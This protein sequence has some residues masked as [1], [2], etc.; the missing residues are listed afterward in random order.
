[1]TCSYLYAALFLTLNGKTISNNSYLSFRTLDRNFND[2]L[3]C[4]GRGQEVDWY[5]LNEEIVPQFS[6]EDSSIQSIPTVLY[7]RKYRTTSHLFREGVSPLLGQYFCSTTD[8]IVY[9]HIGKT[10]CS[11]SAPCM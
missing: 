2:A 3:T 11:Y 5:Y 9:I 6:W 10:V 4:N 7:A 8:Q 1:M